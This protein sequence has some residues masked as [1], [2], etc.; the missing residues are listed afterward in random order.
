M[1]VELHTPA[2][3]AEPLFELWG[4][5]ITNSILGT[6]LAM[7][8]LLV[9]LGLATRR[10]RT[11][12]RGSQ[13]L[14]EILYEQLSG[15]V[16]TVMDN[17]RLARRFTPLIV[18]VFLFV[19]F[20]N[21]V[22]L[23]PGFGTVGGHDAHGEFVPLLR[24]GSADLNLTFAIAGVAFIVVQTTGIV[25]VGLFKY[26]G[27]FVNLSH[28]FKR[29]FKARNLLMVIP[30]F[31]LGLTELISEIAKFIALSF[32][33]FGNI[34]AGEVL[35]VVFGTLLPVFI[36]LSAPFY[37]LEIFVGLIQ[38]FVFAMLTIVFIKIASLA[39]DH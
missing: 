27:K 31:L 26:F 14:L 29:P 24:A 39:H 13:S 4:I 34:Y 30:T 17:E 8:L 25:V 33:L 7:A 23:L 21:W 20:S 37:L 15:I 35:L 36:P 22:G 2:L 6:W 28:L 16:N 9:F 12:P 5:P 32:R 19:L 10:L 11:V 3:H 38:A 18:T 1:A